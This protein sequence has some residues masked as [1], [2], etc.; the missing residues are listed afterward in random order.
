MHYSLK[1]IKVI[2]YKLFSISNAKSFLRKS[3]H[4]S[5]LVPCILPD[6]S[7]FKKIHKVL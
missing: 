1:F 3:L 5:I 2:S 7:Y 4:E 6:V